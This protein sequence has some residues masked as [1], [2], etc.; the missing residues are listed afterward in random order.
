LPK[1][2]VRLKEIINRRCVVCGKHIQVTVYEDG[3]YR[4]GVYWGIIPEF[5]L[6][7]RPGGYDP[8]VADEIWSHSDEQW[9]CLRCFRR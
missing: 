1:L 7:K 6:R 3:R 4:G 9:E 2:E 5:A 8:A